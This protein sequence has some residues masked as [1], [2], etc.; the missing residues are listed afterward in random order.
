MKSPHAVH[1]REVWVI[2]FI[3]GVIM[4]NFPFI[5]IFNKGSLFLGIPILVLYL[6]V[7]WPLSIVVVYFFCQGLKKANEARRDDDSEGD[8]AE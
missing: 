1:F 7:G 5:H 8:E 2:F 3:L 6:F 4:L